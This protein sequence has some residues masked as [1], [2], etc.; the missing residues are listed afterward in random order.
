MT[1]TAEIWRIDG[2]DFNDSLSTV[3]VHDGLLF[4]AD[5]PGF[6]HCLEADTGKQLWSH[7]HLANIWGSPLVA[8]RKVYVQTGEGVVHIFEAG[9]EKK[10]LAKIGTLPDVA[11]GTPV[12]A[13]GVLYITGQTKLYAIAAQN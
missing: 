10:L 4:A 7:D 3:A 8:E 9:R 13:N 12:A 5:A 1:K 2:N 11:H 6:L